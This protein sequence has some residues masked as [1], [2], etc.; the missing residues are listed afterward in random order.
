MFG[1]HIEDGSVVDNIWKIKEDGRYEVTGVNSDGKA[2]ILNEYTGKE[3][4]DWIKEDY[5]RREI[6]FNFN[7]SLSNPCFSNLKFVP[8]YT[9]RSY[10]T[11]VSVDVSKVLD[12]YD[13]I[14]GKIGVL[15]V[16]NT[17][18]RHFLQLF[19]WVID[20]KFFDKEGKELS[21]VPIW[22]TDST[23]IVG[24]AIDYIEIN[25]I[26]FRYTDHKGE[27]CNLAL[28]FRKFDR[29][30][31]IYNFDIMACN[32]YIHEGIVGKKHLRIFTKRNWVL[33]R[34]T[35]MLYLSKNKPIQL[36]NVKDIDVRYYVF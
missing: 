12:Y 33:N 18:S 3:L 36:L 16:G 13:D 20:I 32:M 26:K 25:G 22:N 11:I 4:L 14:K 19:E 35:G 7:G 21:E 8:F 28:A 5:G 1:I 9:D 6:F 31:I 34:Q 15:R 29:N 30:D 23:I 17:V 24:N 2:V 27:I 10:Y